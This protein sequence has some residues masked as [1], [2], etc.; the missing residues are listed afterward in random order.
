MYELIIRLHLQPE[1]GF[2]IDHITIMEDLGQKSVYV[3]VSEI[4]LPVK[5]ICTLANT[6]I[7]YIEVR[8]INPAR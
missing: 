5:R 7:H 3:S 6:E 4:S 1:V 8:G 2:D